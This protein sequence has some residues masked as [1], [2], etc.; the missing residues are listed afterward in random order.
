[1]ILPRALA[2][3]ATLVLVGLL[4]AGCLTMAPDGSLTPATDLVVDPAYRFEIGASL[5]DVIGALG[6]PEKGPFHD[7]YSNTREVVYAFDQAVLRVETR[8]PNGVVRT[9]MAKRIHMFFDANDILIRLTH[10]P[11]RYYSWFSTMPVHAVTVVAH[12]TRPNY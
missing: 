8:M 9:E 3:L 7:R 5:H 1:M 10:Q 11:N 2:T 6:H 12:Q 4:P